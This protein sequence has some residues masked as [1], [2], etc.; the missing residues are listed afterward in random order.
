[1]VIQHY[2]KMYAGR[3][4]VCF[5]YT[6]IHICHLV[7]TDEMSWVKISGYHGGE[8]KNDCLLCCSAVQKA[9]LKCRQMSTRL[10]GVTIN[11]MT[12]L[13]SWVGV[14]FRMNKMNWFRCVKMFENVEKSVTRNDFAYVTRHTCP[15][16]KHCWQNVQCKA[17]AGTCLLHST[18]ELSCLQIE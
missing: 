1:M 13:M 7:H 17:S 15:F 5:I 2:K 12:I 6:V 8:Y 18:T 16:Q 10:Y 4:R 9:Y 14:R 11:Q 3:S